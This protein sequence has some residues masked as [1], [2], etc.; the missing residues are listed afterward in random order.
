MSYT[1]PTTKASGDLVTAA[2]WNTDITENIKYLRALVQSG[3]EAFSSGGSNDATVTVTF[4]TAFASTP[5]VVAI[6]GSEH[7]GIC[8]VTARSTT[9][10]T[11]KLIGVGSS[12]SGTI[13]WMAH[14][15][16]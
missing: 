8:R 7:G 16:P 6:V 10:A 2:A 3:S 12:Q 14:V 5:I 9:Q 13:L 11:I 1:V 4:P 15:A